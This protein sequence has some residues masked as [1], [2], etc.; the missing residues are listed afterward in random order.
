MLFVRFSMQAVKQAVVTGC[1]LV[2]AAVQAQTTKHHPVLM[3]SI[4]AMNPHYLFEAK[5][6]AKEIPF[7]LSLLNDGAYAKSVINVTPTIT[8]PNHV[9]L[10]T[11]TFPAKHGIFNNMLEDPAANIHG[12][13]MEYGNAIRV[14]T[15]WEST[16]AAGLSTASVNWPV[17]LGARGIDYN[18]PQITMPD[19]AENHFLREIVSRPDGLLEHIEQTIGMYTPDTDEDLFATRSRSYSSR[20]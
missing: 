5:E 8:N 4:D 11:G 13:Q 9:T 16:K 14:P 17:S 18:I 15:L 3:I 12:L 10:V 20:T 19:T 1:L 6:H 2:V 7:L